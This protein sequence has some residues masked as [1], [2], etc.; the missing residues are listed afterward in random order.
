MSSH[1]INIRHYASNCQ[2]SGINLHISCAKID[3]FSLKGNKGTSLINSFEN[4]KNLIAE[5]Y[6]LHTR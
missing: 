3:L 2:H 5:K 6:A 1:V 4:L